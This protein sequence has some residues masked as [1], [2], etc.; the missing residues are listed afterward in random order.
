L[1]AKLQRLKNAWAE[2]TMGLANNEVIKGAVDLITSLL[3]GVNN[4]TD[5]GSDGLGGLMTTLLR[6]GTVIA[7]LKGG[8][9]IIEGLL[10]LFINNKSSLGKKV[11]EESGI[12]FGAALIKRF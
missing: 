11:Y 7:S 10:K 9:A 12:S 2:F 8:K 6:L 3:E 5:V 4:L 1:D